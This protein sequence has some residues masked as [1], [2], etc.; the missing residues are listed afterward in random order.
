MYRHSASVPGNNIGPVAKPS[1]TNQVSD[2]FD[3]DMSVLLEQKRRQL[4]EEIVQFKALKDKEFQDF[5]NSLRKQRRKRKREAKAQKEASGT[6]EPEARPGALSLLGGINKN[7][8]Q[9]NGDTEFIRKSSDKSEDG[10]STRHPSSSQPTTSLDRQNIKGETT[11]PRAGSPLPTERLSKQRSRSPPSPTLAHTPP[12]GWSRNGPIPPT[13]T[14]ENHDSFTGVFTPAYLPLLESKAAKDILHS[15]KNDPKLQR[16]NSFSHSRTSSNILSPT[17][18]SQRSQTAPILPSTS[19]P[20]ALRTA[21]GS[22]VR[23]RKHVTFKLADSVV[24]DPSSSYEEGP[25]PEPREEGSDEMHGLDGVQSNGKSHAEGNTSDEP[26]AGLPPPIWKRQIRSPI[27]KGRERRPSPI[28]ANPNL[29]P[30]ASLDLADDGGSGVGFFE[31]DEEIASPGFGEVRPFEM[32]EA[33]DLQEDETTN[34]R[35]TKRDY[36]EDE[37]GQTYEYGGSVPIDIRPT[38]SWVGTFGH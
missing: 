14:K 3:S 16:H 12:K 20:S 5:E 27:I 26:E 8:N 22:A 23:R 9:A 28:F 34:E 37:K 18:R 13:P 29:S 35:G 32:D 21:S 33:D 2:D 36:F 24:V 6:T 11:P 19:L 4:D 31:L 15:Q 30:R 25:S 10:V 7:S 1:S 17:S 38:G